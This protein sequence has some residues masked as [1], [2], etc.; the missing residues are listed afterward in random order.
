MHSLRAD[1]GFSLVEVLMVVAIIGLMAGVVVLSLPNESQNVRQALNR[2]ERAMVALSRDSILTGRVLGLVFNRDG[3]ET[4]QL[5]D[6]GWVLDNS[7]LKLDARRWQP[8]ALT[9][10][11]VEGADI[12]LAASGLEPQL[13]FLPTGEHPAFELSFEGQ[14]VRAALVAQ[15]SANPQVRYEE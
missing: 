3:F 13:W 7:T 4:V 10:V 15:A 14:N 6:D 11:Q 8:L 2:T 5:T 1:R 9:S 12:S